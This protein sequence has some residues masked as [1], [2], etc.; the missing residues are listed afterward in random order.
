MMSELGVTFEDRG[1]LTTLA[2]LVRVQAGALEFRTL[3]PANR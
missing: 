1:L 2:R 3:P